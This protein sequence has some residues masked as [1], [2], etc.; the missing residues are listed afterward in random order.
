MY[1]SIKS[2]IRYKGIKSD[3][4][5][6]K[7]GVKQCD[8]STSLLCL[9]FLND[10]IQHINTDK[11]GIMTL[12]ELKLFYCSMPTTRSFLRKTPAHYN[13]CYLTSKLTVAHGI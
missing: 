13:P 2:C 5:N 11:D 12:E 9:F 8:P 3:F 4:I 1:C 10:I 7:I 6:S